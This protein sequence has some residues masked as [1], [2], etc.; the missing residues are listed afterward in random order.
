MK[1]FANNK[2]IIDFNSCQIDDI[3]A[4]SISLSLKDSKT[5]EIFQISNN[6]FTDIGLIDILSNLQWAT[7][8]KELYFGNN[9]NL[10]EIGLSALI[11]V[12]PVFTNLR[13]LGLNHC[14]ITDE[15][16]ILLSYCLE[17]FK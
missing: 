7:C 17:V 15:N 6:D 4:S 12:L 2:K 16:V 13:I 1:E 10:T 9:D 3:D 11:E 8:I 14:G 5:L